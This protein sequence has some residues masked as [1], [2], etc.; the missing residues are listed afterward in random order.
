MEVAPISY[1]TFWI[2]FIQNDPSLL[3]T[4]SLTREFVSKRGLH[5]RIA[6]TFIVSTMILIVAF[7]TLASAMSGY[8]G[9]V[10]AFI[11]EYDQTLT[12]WSKFRPVAYVIHDVDRI[13]WTRDLVVSYESSTNGRKNPQ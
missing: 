4:V 1:Q 7:P 5:S 2:I 3:S 6:M 11:R 12:Q 8:T 13:S 10:E 9:E